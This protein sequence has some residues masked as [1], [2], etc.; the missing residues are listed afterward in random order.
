MS[1]ATSFAFLAIKIPL[2]PYNLE[3]KN[4]HN[5]EEGADRCFMHLYFD[6]LPLEL[7]IF[8]W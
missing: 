4:N 1:K 3:E 5:G 8:W 2:K 7:K 6:F